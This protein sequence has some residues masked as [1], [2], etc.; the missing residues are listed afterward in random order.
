M[1]PNWLLKALTVFSAESIAAIVLLAPATVSTLA[2]AS[3]VVPLAMVVAL[4][5]PI[6]TP[7]VDA[8]VIVSEFESASVIVPLDVTPAPVLAML[9]AAV[10]AVKPPVADPVMAWITLMSRPSAADNVILLLVS[11]LAVTP[12]VFEALLICGT[13]CGEVSVGPPPVTSAF[14]KIAVP[15]I[16]RLYA[17]TAVPVPATDVKAFESTALVVA[18]A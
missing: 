5:N 8:L 10:P 2:L 4:V 16:V 3:V 11:T 12:V 6:S 18:L 17:P 15:L 1:A 13:T 9:P 14:E 7:A